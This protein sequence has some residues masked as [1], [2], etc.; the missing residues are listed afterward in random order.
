VF[1]LVGGLVPGS[2]GGTGSYCCS[3]YEAANPF[4]SLGT[5]SGSF[6]GDPVFRP[7]DGCEHSRLY[8]PGT[9]ITSQETAIS[10]S[11]QQ[12]LLGIH[13]RVWFWWLFIGWIPQVGQSLDGHSFSHCFTLCLCNS[14]HGY[15]VLPSKKD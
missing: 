3:S 11:C 14:F 10:G 6:I 13:N 12:A 9:G 4:S 15:F 2:S 8:L 7:M 5:F 1:S